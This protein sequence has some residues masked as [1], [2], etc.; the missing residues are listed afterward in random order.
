M[1]SDPK[2]KEL[3]R[4]FISARKAAP[5]GAACEEGFEAR[6]MA[7]VRAA[8]GERTPFF[9]W[10]WR[11]IPV[12]ATLVIMIGIWIFMLRPRPAIDLSALTRIG[13]EEAV[14]VASLT[15]GTR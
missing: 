9:L 10:E 15:G 6:V 12:F 13:S 2:D 14:L 5:Y 11:L 8:R 3:E 4:L 1:E 7:R